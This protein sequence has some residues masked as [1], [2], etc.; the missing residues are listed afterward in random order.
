MAVRSAKVS[1]FRGGE[2]SVGH[3]C[4]FFKERP[5]CVVDLSYEFRCLRSNSQGLERRLDLVLIA[6]QDLIK[7]EGDTQLTSL[8]QLG[9]NLVTM[10]IQTLLLRRKTKCKN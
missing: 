1:L 7:L 2:W 6:D 8:Y 4:N 10:M 3:P 5:N 9:I